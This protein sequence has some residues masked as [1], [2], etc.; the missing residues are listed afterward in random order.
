MLVTVKINILKLL[1]K[2][3]PMMCYKPAVFPMLVLHRRCRFL[4]YG[5]WTLD[6]SNN[7]YF[8]TQPY[9]K[10][11]QYIYRIGLAPM[12]KYQYPIYNNN[13]NYINMALYY[14]TTTN[15]NFYYIPQKLKRRTTLYYYYTKKNKEVGRDFEF[16]KFVALSLSCPSSLTFAPNRR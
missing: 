6:S 5:L 15:K 13:L 14:N 1:N 8:A 16:L 9:Q 11:L 12:V 2:V 7:K 10:V 3:F 4:Y